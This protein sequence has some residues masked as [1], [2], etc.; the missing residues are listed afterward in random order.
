MRST[1]ETQFDVG[2]PWSP[3]P[4]TS[5]PPSS[6]ATRSARCAPTTA[7]T[8]SASCRAAPAEDRVAGLDP[9]AYLPDRYVLAGREIHL[10]CPNGFAETAVHQ[11]VPREAAR[12]RGDHQELAH[13]AR[14]AGPAG[15]SLTGP[16]LAGVG[17]APVGVA[18]GIGSLPGDDIDAAVAMVFDALPD[19]PH[20]PELPDRGPGSDLVGRTAT[21]L[22]DLPV[23]L[24][25]VG[26]AAGR[27][28]GPRR[29]TRPRS[30][31]PRPRCARS[32]RR[33]RVR[34]P[35]QAAARRALDAGGVGRAAPRRSRARGRRC[36]P[37]PRPAR[38]PRRSAGISTTRRRRLPGAELVL[39]LDEPSLPG[40]LAGTGPDGQRVRPGP[41]GRGGRR[42]LCAAGGDHG[43][44]RGAGRRALLR[45]RGAAPAAPRGRACPGSASTSRAAVGSPRTRSASW[46][47]PASR[48]WLGVVPALGPGVAPT[49]HEVGR[50]GPRV[51][52][53]AR[54]RAPSCSRRSVAFT[55]SCGLA[56]ASI[57]WARTAYRLLQQATRRLVEAPDGTP[58]MTARRRPRQGRAP[59]R[60]AQPAAR[61]PR[62]PLLH[63]QPADRLRRRV[64]REDARAAG[65][66][67]RAPEPADAELADPEGHGDA[68]DGL[69]RGPARASGCSAST[70]S[71]PT[72]SSPAWAARATRE[73][74]VPHWLCELKI[75]GLAVDLVYEDGRLVRAAT[76][77][78]GRDRRGHHLQPAHHRHRART[79]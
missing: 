35:A 31:R 25:P 37:G 73:V 21:N 57:G 26:L 56:G 38:S 2:S 72:R 3:V 1:V 78:D 41:A 10:W 4:M 23:D 9:D 5:W 62:L 63:Q 77:G 47:R 75:D 69:R 28:P 29:A 16:R 7:G 66:R 22:V 30:A 19:L 13:R 79:G 36:G 46:S 27:A 54:V 24:Q 32:G 11:H 55:P 15:P 42:A 59:P 51:V 44:R 65:D 34:R 53:S 17:G 70:T 52:A 58:C 49:A 14:A 60:R 64:R 39:Q 12:R 48:V 50:A 18:T 8:A 45:R 40:V 74:P 61:G 76:R 68:V 43:G 20:L 67:G 71:S 6:P 33:P